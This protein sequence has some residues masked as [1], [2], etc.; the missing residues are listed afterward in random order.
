MSGLGWKIQGAGGTTKVLLAGSLD[1]TA[2]FAELLTELAKSR[3]IR[4]DVSGVSR[5]NSSGVREWI[6]FIRAIPG[7]SAV[8]LEKCTPTLVSQLNVIHKFA[9][10]AKI[11]SVY[12]PFVCP[13]CNSEETVLFDVTGDRAALAL[14]SVKCKSCRAAMELDD[15]E[16]SYFAFLDAR[17]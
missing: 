2:N 15:H 6:N 16:E 7:A 8:E 9:G 10:E 5:I 4:L 3:T 17:D 11:L 12:A 14:S 1:E 13:R